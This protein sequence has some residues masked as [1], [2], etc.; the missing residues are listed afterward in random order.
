MLLREGLSEPLLKLRR[1]DLTGLR[2]ADFNEDLLYDVLGGLWRTLLL[3]GE[4][5][6]LLLR[7]R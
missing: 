5:V 1:E 4:P 3:V 7:L 6:A 2:L